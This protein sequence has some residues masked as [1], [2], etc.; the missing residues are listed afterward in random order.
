MYP[1]GTLADW[2]DDRIVYRNLVPADRT[3]PSLK[4]VWQEIGLERY[5]IPRKTEPAYAAAV[6][7]FLETAI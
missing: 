2:I 1:K 4:D 6:S 3:L 5:R 7:R